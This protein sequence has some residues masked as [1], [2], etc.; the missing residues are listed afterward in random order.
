MQQPILQIRDKLF[1]GLDQEYNVVDM[2][3][4]VDVLSQLENYAITKEAL[5]ATRLGKHINELRRKAQDKLLANRAKSLV[6]KWR[7]LLVVPNSTTETPPPGGGGAGSLIVQNHTTATTEKPTLN[8]GS[9]NPSFSSVKNRHLSPAI[10]PLSNGV[11]NTSPGI[12]NNNHSLPSSASTSPGLSRPTTPTTATTRLNNSNGRPV[13]PVVIDSVSKTNPANKRLRKD[14]SPNLV[15]PPGKRV[16]A[17]GDQDFLLDTDT[18]DSFVSVADSDNAAKQSVPDSNKNSFL[19]PEDDNNESNSSFSKQQ[20]QRKTRMPKKLAEQKPDTL[21]RQ[22][23]SVRKAS[24]KVL[25]TQDLVQQ[26]ALRSQSPV[27]V[28]NNLN[29]NNHHHHAL[30]N[31]NNTELPSSQQ[32]TNSQLMSRF[33]DSQDRLSPPV[34]SSATSPDPID[35]TSSTRCS[36]AAALHPPSNNE[37]KGDAVDAILSQ[38]PPINREEILAEIQREIAKEEDEEEI[39]GLIPIKKEP[40]AEITDELVEKLHTDQVESLTGNFDAEGAFHEWHEVVGKTS[41]EGDLLYILPYCI[42]D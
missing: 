11:R 29:E 27:L 28:S 33:F 23:Q 13:S 42:I 32:E 1:T 24:G 16:R 21:Q 18:K 40:K 20:L 34:S 12:I 22:M 25:T 41:K 37:E 5:E 2:G 4:V 10:R 39:D 17:N 19:S 8:G 14:C 9:Y 15:V 6:K 30:H 26:L 31:D 38:L 3:V 7:Q 35:S 36:S